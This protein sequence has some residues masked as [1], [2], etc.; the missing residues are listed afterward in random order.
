MMAGRPLVM[1]H[2]WGMSSAVWD[3][4]A[5]EL[6][7]DHRV[8]LLD[9]PGHGDSSL[10][11]R[12]ETLKDWALACLAAAPDGATWLGWSLG[13]LVAMQAALLAPER[14]RSL[15]LVAAT[16]R[17]VQA[18]DWPHAVSET[19]LDQFSGALLRDP[20][21]TLERFLALQVR[22]SAEARETLRRLRTALRERPAPRDSALKVG[23]ELL[24]RSD[25]R[26]E[27]L[28]LLP[29][30]LW[31]LGSRDALVPTAL[32]SW[33]EEMLPAA[34]I[35]TLDGAGHAPFLSHADSFRDR[36]REFLE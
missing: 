6:A 28:R 2:G 1:L 19:T 14:I 11:P 23:L 18:E 32:G 27:L 5:R 24:R 34:R 25:L 4:L 9:L 26:A 10:E 20:G 30:V 33:L 13:G 31:L 36:V 12:E 35:V 3:G 8:M 29:P 7:R 17:F 21:T 22:G 15:V 16:P